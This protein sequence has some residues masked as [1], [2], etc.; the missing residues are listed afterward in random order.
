MLRVREVTTHHVGDEANV[1]IFQSSASAA[2][3]CGFGGP[4]HYSVVTVKPGSDALEVDQ[5]L[6]VIRFQHGHPASVGRNGVTIEALIAICHDR[7]KMFQSGPYENAY[8]ETAIMHLERAIEALK[9]RT[10]ERES[11]IPGDRIKLDDLTK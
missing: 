1:R 2:T 10:R 6:G 9:D 7:L 3:A 8:N 5:A 11:L 4:H